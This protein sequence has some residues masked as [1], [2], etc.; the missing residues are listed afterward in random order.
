MD[1]IYKKVEV[2]GTSPTSFSDAVRSAILR[3]SETIDHI[4]WFEVVEWRGAVTGGEVS[5]FQATVKLGFRVDSH[6]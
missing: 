2:V 5:E 1:K 4:S 6:A 3:A